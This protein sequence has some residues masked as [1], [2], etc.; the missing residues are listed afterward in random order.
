MLD[1]WEREGRPPARDDSLKRPAVDVPPLTTRKPVN[2]AVAIG[3][4][5]VAWFVFCTVLWLLVGKAWGDEPLMILFCPHGV[6]RGSVT[7]I[8]G[9][10]VDRDSCSAC[11]SLEARVGSQGPMWGGID[12]V[13]YMPTLPSS[14]PFFFRDIDSLATEIDSLKA[15]QDRLLEIIE[16]IGGA[17]RLVNEQNKLLRE[18]LKMHK[19]RLDS[20]QGRY[21]VPDDDEP[22]RRKM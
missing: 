2:L 12:G 9:V 22:V 15:D 19:E 13:P 3:L 18:V 17:V 1:S 16:I 10:E 7:E 14:Q 8:D 6:N 5:V 11:D 21:E 20:I 4:A